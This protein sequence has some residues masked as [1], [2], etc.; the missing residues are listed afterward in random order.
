MSISDWV[1]SEYLDVVSRYGPGHD[2]RA[3]V[4]I[5]PRGATY[6]VW[7][8]GPGAPILAADYENPVSLAE[9]KRLCDEALRREP[10]AAVPAPTTTHET[11][12]AAQELIEAREAYDAARTRLKSAEARV[13]AVLSAEPGGDV[14]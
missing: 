11:V 5:H 7:G 4:Y 13:L 9:A 2:L 1:E 10:P 12:A 8:A 3:R 14:P 6:C